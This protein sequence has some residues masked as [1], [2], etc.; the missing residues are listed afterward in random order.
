MGSLHGLRSLLAT[1]R[2]LGRLRLPALDL[3]HSLEAYPTGLVGDWLARRL[4]RPH[5]LTSHGTYGVV[6]HE[7]IPDRFLYAG[8]LRRAALGVHAPAEA[9]L[10]LPPPAS[11][12]SFLRAP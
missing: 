9:E 12:G 4:N 10:L 11:A 3:V 6:W 7:I 2:A 1:H 8:V 5:V